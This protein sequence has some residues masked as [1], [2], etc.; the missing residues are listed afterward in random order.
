MST[1]AAV[2]LWFAITCYVVLGGADYGAGFWDL[3]AGGARRGARPRALIDQAMTPVW[4]ANNVWL[5]FALVVLWTAF[6]RAFASI[7]SALFVPMSLA[8]GGIVLRGAAFVFRKPIQALTGRRILGAAF[9]LSS[10]VTPFFLGA[11]FG[12]I[13]SGRIRAGDP[14]GDPAAAWTGPTSMLIGTLAVV[15]AAFLAAVFLVFDARRA[16]DQALEHYFRRRAMG[17]AAVAGLVAVAGL[18]VLRGDAPYLFHGLLR[19]GLPLVLISAACG[20]GVL[21]LLSR[22]ITRGT[23]GLAVGA[24]VAV[25]AGWGL[26]QYPYLLPT[27]LTIQAGAGA[28]ATLTWVLVVFLAAAV[29]AVPALGLLYVLDQRGH[30]QEAATEA[31]QE[32]VQEPIV[33][34][35]AVG[36]KRDRSP[37]ARPHWWRRAFGR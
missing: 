15:C 10:V 19:Q 27:S 26:A 7:M 37:T 22:R 4:E 20:G 36:T 13:A 12:G 31:P 16:R 9:A 35:G 3:T 30:L 33:H 32:P 34:R 24:V 14:G 11:A 6:P 2:I 21:A 25:L 5:I 8:A 17:S 28:P 23:R 18:F 29:T 1:I